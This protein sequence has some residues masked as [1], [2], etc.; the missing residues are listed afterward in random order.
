MLL[1]PLVQHLLFDITGVPAASLLL[2]GFGFSFVL[3]KLLQVD[4]PD[5]WQSLVAFNVGVE[6]GQLLIIL[7]AW[8]LF[9][10]V[11]RMN[12]RAWQVSRWGIAASCAV[13][14]VFWAAQ[15]TSAVIAAI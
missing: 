15:R 1:C 6:I 14:A 3:H 5:M 12:D 11:E 9:R 2:H 10:L 8:P 4:S 13:V 7:C